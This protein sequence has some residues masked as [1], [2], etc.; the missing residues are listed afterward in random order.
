LWEIA[1]GT[2]HA[3]SLAKMNHFANKATPITLVSRVDPSS[4]PTPVPEPSPAPTEPVTPDSPNLPT[5]E[6]EPPVTPID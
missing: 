6:D 2:P 5:Y 1:L 4:R 3:L